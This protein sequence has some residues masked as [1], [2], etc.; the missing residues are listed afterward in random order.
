MTHYSDDE[1]VLFFYG[2][3]HR[4]EAVQHHLD[5]CLACAALYH[6]I[7]RTMKLV[8]VPS[9]PDRGERYGLEVW[10]RIRPLLPIQAPSR[11]P[12]WWQWNH[13]VS[14]G[15]I[16]ALLVAAFVAGRMWPRP[17]DARPAAVVR[18]AVAST[19]PGD[20]V[21][22]AAIGDHLEQSERLLLDFVNAGGQIVDVSG[23]RAA[24][25]DL[26]ESNRFYREAANQAGD[27]MVVDVLETLERSLIEIAHTPSTLNFADFSKMRMRLDAAALLFKVRVLSDE[28]HEREMSDR[29]PGKTT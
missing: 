9:E 3:G 29:K 13:L 27:A 17:E 8:T 16:A 1:L 28:L 21:R 18:T 15:A 6:D 14:G 12:A 23:E 25:S 24:A 26:V 5:A 2:E 20:R 11:A 19:D 10:Q 7:A 22:L 4:P